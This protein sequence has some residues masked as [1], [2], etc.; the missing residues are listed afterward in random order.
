M[1]VSR[2]LR[3]TYYFTC[4]GGGLPSPSAIV[5]NNSVDS[6]YLITAFLIK[7]FERN[8]HHELDIM[9]LQTQRVKYIL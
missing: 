1:F 6:H 9:H 8:F 2:T 4:P 3:F 5:I 7:L